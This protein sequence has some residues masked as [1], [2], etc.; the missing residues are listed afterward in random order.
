ME[1][2]RYWTMN[3]WNRVTAPAYNLKVYNVIPLELQDKVYELM[4][5]EDFYF[6]INHLIEQFNFNNGY[7]WQAGFNGRS[8]GYLV[9]YI[10]GEDDGSVYTRPGTQIEDEDVPDYIMERFDKLAK[11]IVE[12]TIDMAKNCTIAE[13]EETQVVK[14]KVIQWNK[15]N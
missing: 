7:E 9:L 5:I 8:G 1:R 6:V 12:T 2:I 3:S 14:R 13:E 11:E 10:G 15:T 4:D